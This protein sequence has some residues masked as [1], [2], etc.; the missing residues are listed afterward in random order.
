MTRSAIRTIFASAAA[1]FALAAGAAPAQAQE[2]GEASPLAAEAGARLTAARELVALLEVERQ[3]DVAMEALR[4]TLVNSIAGGLAQ[5]NPARSALEDLDRSYPGGSRAFTEAF[6]DRYTEIFRGYY[7]QMIEEAARY[8][9]ANLSLEQ[10]QGTL[11]F[12]RSEVGGAWI[13]LMP[14]IQRHMA[15]LGTQYGLRAGI[16]AAG[17]LLPTVGADG[18]DSATGSNLDA[19]RAPAEA[20]PQDEPEE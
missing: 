6:A 2:T 13:E 10:L 12:Y 18:G 9:A 17:E 5:G 20:P 15:Q 16:E 7:P 1:A 8:Y 19:M 4:P 11:E 14:G 3:L